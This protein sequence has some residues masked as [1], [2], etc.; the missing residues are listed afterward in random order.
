MKKLKTV[1]IIA[2][3][4]I[5]IDFAFS[6]P[7]TE[8]VQ[9]YNSPG[10]YNDY[11]T[12][13]KTDGFGNI[14]LCGYVE[15]ST[16]NSDVLLLKYNS[17]GNLI[18]SRTWRGI[19]SNSNKSSKILFDYEGFI[20]ILGRASLNYGDFLLIKYNSNG[21]TLWSRTFD[22]MNDNSDDAKDMVIDR[23]NNIYVT[24]LLY[25]FGN[26]D[27]GTI[28]FDRNG[29]LKWSKKF[30]G[31]T[32][33]N[34]LIDTN[35]IYIAGYSNSNIA[36]LKYD[37]LGNSIDTF[38]CE[39][40][41]SDGAQLM[42]F[43][44]QKNLVVSGLEDAGLPTQYNIVTSKISEYGVKNWINI[45]N[46]NSDNF[47]EYLYDLK[48]DTTGNNLILVRSRN[49]IYQRAEISLIKYDNTTGDSLWIRKFNLVPYSNDEPAKMSIDKNNNIYIVGKG[50]SNFVFD[51]ILIIK[52]NTLGQLQWH[53]VYYPTL[54]SNS[55]GICIIT[56]SLGNIYT[57]GITN[58]AMTGGDDIVL[59]KYSQLTHTVENVEG[60]PEKY[61]LFQNYPNPFNSTTQIGFDLIKNGKYKIEIFDILGRS[62]DIILN[63]FKNAGSYKINYNAS[64]LSSGIYL[65]SLSSS[66]VQIIRKFILI[67]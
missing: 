25:R 22:G 30:N 32:V 27:N 43:D 61:Q 21:D 5:V 55:T 29:N 12:D 62:V 9:R 48:T 14:Y 31:F 15:Y 65:Y 28:K 53:K 26:I 44:A 24:G 63:E 49:Q 46:N 57:S 7:Q 39:T 42:V 64:N 23:N 38:Y 33:G 41:N 54:F 51:R 17:T 35:Y 37:T 34:I 36:I 3:Y 59:V 67:K 40:L 4:F 60:I 18:W 8:W 56:D 1:F 6:Q 2:I 16:S 45:F 20:Y 52:Y 50:D 58:S 10:N 11:V 19:N 66:D 13:M 47:T